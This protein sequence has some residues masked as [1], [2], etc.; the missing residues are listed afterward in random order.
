MRFAPTASVGLALA[1]ASAA[2]YGLNAVTAQMAAAAGLGGALVV[3]WRV[4]LMLA[5][6][7][8]IAVVWRAS[9]A[10]EPQERPV[11]I[12]FGLSSAIIGMAYLSS[13]AFL[14]VSVAVVVFYLFPIFIVLAEP[15]VEHRRFSPVQ[16]VVVA[17]GFA[18]VA[19]VVGGHGG[20]M[21][22]RGLALALL[23]AMGAAVQF[24]AATR[25]PRSG[26][27]A[28][29]FWSH[30]IVLPVVSATLLLIGGF[31]GPAA[32]AAAPWAMAVTIGA[33]LV[34]FALQMLALAR[35]PAAIGG[36]AYLTEPLFATAFAALLLGERLGGWQY[37]GAALTLAAVGLNAARALAAEKALKQA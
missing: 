13:V 4:A 7:S 23:A 19:L 20:A 32:F 2:G 29:L 24:F 37:L 21:D 16:F 11:L 10:V 3:F 33:Y 17:I 8:L 25:M 35:V 5:V 9:L 27:A 22:W 12:V 6:L 15:F 36:L 28:K 14:P 26:T 18:G 34:S 1:V 30:M 31:K